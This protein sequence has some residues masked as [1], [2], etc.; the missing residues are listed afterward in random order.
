MFGGVASHETDIYSLGVIIIELI[1][2]S[3]E[4]PNIIGVSMIYRIISYYTIL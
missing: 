2:G 3:K 1:T 4:K